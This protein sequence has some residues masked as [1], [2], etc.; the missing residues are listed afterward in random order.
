MTYKEKCPTCY[1]N[2]LEAQEQARLNGMGSERE[3]RLMARIA[4]L[5]KQHKPD[6]NTSDEVALWVNAMRYCM[7]RNTYAVDEF[8][9]MCK[10]HWPMLQY[11]TQEVLMR[12]LLRAINHETPETRLD[13]WLE[14]QEFIAANLST[15]SEAETTD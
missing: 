13:D 15:N 12:D 2:K 3:A 7:G 1:E 11:R 4:E 6:Y 8:I 5:E 9:E 10:R 14:L